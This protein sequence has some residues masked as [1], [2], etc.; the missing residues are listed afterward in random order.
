[1]QTTQANA[2]YQATIAKL[3]HFLGR[4]L[5]TNKIARLTLHPAEADTGY[6][7]RRIDVTQVH[8]LIHA[9]WLNVSDT[10]LSTT[11]SN[12]MGVSVKTVEHLIA[13][14]SACGI[15]NCRIDIDGPEVPIMDGSA[16]PFVLQ[17]L[18]AGIK[19]LQQERMAVVITKPLWI[20]EGGIKAGL[21]PYPEPAVDISIDFEQSVIGKQRIATTINSEIFYKHLSSAR[22]FGFSEQIET[23]QKLGFAQ[24]GSLQN[25]IL[26]RNNAV[27]NPEGLRF[28]NEF[29][30]HK[31]LDAIGDLALLGVKIVGCF[32]GQ[33]SGHHLNN[34]LLRHLMMHSDSWK[35]VSYREA[36][37]NWE[38]LVVSD[39]ATGLA[40]KGAMI[41]V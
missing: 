26:I 15:D 40:E 32:V 10:H 39:Q 41:G 28:E 34:Q 6:V 12:C 9:R 4:G 8:N 38:A 21:V 22:T 13:A 35:Y 20:S 11:V 30:R 7:F 17:I 3:T 18:A 27:V 19:S 16:N 37:E 31:A 29:V 25:A 36:M 1:M 2:C 5:H 23:L 24:G 33:C 14:L